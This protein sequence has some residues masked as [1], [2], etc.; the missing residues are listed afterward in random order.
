MIHFTCKEC[1]RHVRVNDALAG[2]KGRCPFCKKVIAIPPAAGPDADAD[3]GGNITALAAALEAGDDRPGQAK[4][5]PPPPGIEEGRPEDFELH[6]AKSDTAGETDILP[7][8]HHLTD[9]APSPT[10][11]A[12]PEQL[13]D[14]ANR[15]PV[16]KPP[17]T[18][19]KRMLFIILAITV[20]VIA[21]AV[22][23]VCL[24][25]GD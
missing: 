10:R 24:L 16:G 13:Q 20:V 14:Q 1:D 11:S 23:V 18:V 6:P 5:V 15:Q 25:P 7:A 8:Q 21:V 12:E 17:Q 9:E 2:Q 22:T 3:K 19:R 4:A